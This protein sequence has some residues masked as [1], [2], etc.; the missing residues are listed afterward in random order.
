VLIDQL[1]KYG[2]EIPFTA[3]IKKIDRYYTLS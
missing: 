3:T 2:N 1:E